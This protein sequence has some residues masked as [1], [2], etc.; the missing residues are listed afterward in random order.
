MFRATLERSL[1]LVSDEMQK[2]YEKVERQNAVLHKVVTR[3]VSEDVAKEVLA[4][5]AND[6]SDEEVR[7]V[8]GREPGEWRPTPPAYA[9]PLV[10]QWPNVTCFSLR[11]GF[12]FR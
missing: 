2:L 7:Y 12:Q 5:R 8:V 1:A 3:Y 9:K 11:R 10:P 4:W 6:K